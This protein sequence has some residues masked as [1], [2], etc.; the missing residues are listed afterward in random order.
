MNDF[1]FQNRTKIYFGK[2]QLTHLGEEAAA[3]GKKYS[4]S[5]AAAPLNESA[6]MIRSSMF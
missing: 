4:S 5:T 2:D 6:F 3:F 1:V